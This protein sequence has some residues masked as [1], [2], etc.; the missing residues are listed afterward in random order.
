MRVL[1]NKSAVCINYHL[2][3]AYIYIYIYIYTYIYITVFHNIRDNKITYH[4]YIIVQI[5]KRF[6]QSNSEA[7]DVRVEANLLETFTVIAQFLLKIQ[8]I[9][10][11]DLEMKVK[12][13]EVRHP[14]C[15]HL[16]GNIKIY[17]RKYTRLRLLSPFLR[18]QHFKLLTLKIRSKS[19]NTTFAMMQFDGEYLPT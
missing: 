16:M 12:V 8:N 1:I 9:K 5:F 14:Q 4:L 2:Y 17:I 7:G 10:T 19:W 18:Y 6:K 11:C 13:M 3:N 15:C